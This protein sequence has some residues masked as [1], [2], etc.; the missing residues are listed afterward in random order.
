M[1]SEES[2]AAAVPGGSAGFIAGERG[3]AV[4]ARSLASLQ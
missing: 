2:V 3:S 4:V 1:N